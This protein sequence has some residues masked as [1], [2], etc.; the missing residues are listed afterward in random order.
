MKIFI[1]N[2][3]KNEILNRSPAM[4]LPTA[5]PILTETQGEPLPPTGSVL[6]QHMQKAQ[7]LASLR[8]PRTSRTFAGEAREGRVKQ[9]R[10]DIWTDPKLAY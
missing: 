2:L 6:A 4:P 1:I 5:A 7:P 9:A 8:E 3:R 10:K